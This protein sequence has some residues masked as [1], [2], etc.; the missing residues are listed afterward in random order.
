MLILMARDRNHAHRWI[1]F[2][3]VLFVL[4]GGCRPANAPM[5][6]YLIGEWRTSATTHAG[7]TMELTK[8]LV[9]FQGKD[10]TV[11]T[12]KIVN[13]VTIQEK[14]AT[15]HRISYVDLDKNEYRLD[16]IYN[17]ANGGTMRFKNQPGLVWTRIGASL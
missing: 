12:G 10:D 6:D 8:D 9:R 11:V 2:G 14:T 17:P 1:C 5:P 3:I 16:I 13:F 7:S 4:A 15:Y